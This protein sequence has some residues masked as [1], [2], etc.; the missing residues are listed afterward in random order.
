[1]ALNAWHAVIP[2]VVRDTTRCHEYWGS[3]FEL[4]L[5]LTFVLSATGLGPEP[6]IRGGPASG[7]VGQHSLGPIVGRRW[8]A[9]ARLS[10]WLL[11]V[12]SIA[13]FFAA[14]T[15]RDIGGVGTGWNGLTANNGV[16][17]VGTKDGRVQA[18]IDN[19]FE[20]VRPGWTFPQSEGTDDLQ[21]VYAT[22]LVAGELLYVAAESGYLYALEVETGTVSDRGWRRPLGIQVELEPLVAGPAYDAINELVLIPSEDG[23]LYGYDDDTGEEVWDRPFSAEDKIWSTPAVSNGVAFFGSHDGNVYSVNLSSGEENWSFRT[24]G[25]VAG[26]P[27]LVDGMVVVGSFDKKLYA[28]DADDSSLRWE[29]EGANWFWAGAVSNGSLIF[30]PNMD[31]NIYALDM[32]GN[33]QWKFDAGD[34]IVSPPVLV[35]RGLV[36][37]ARNGRLTLLDVSSSGSR[38]AG[39]RVLSSQ[40]LGDSEVR[41]PIVAVGD[42]VYVGS[43]DG[44]VRR[45][46]VKGGQVQMWCWH[47]ENTVCN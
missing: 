46:E 37:A 45:V 10:L 6:A 33:L 44:S 23:N 4:N 3:S 16:V 30:A 15:G 19:G 24:G 42:S 22:P 20:G 8:K 40:T 41:A 13:V 35:P 17:Y 28:L 1:M 32:E 2:G 14:C 26:K 29:F 7:S 12:A 9:P 27:L 43:E 21:G 31:G 5:L 39:Q 47:H 18:L 11:L 38:S 36:V 25:V 34:S